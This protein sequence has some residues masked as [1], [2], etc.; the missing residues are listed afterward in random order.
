MRSEVERGDERD[1]RMKDAED[2]SRGVV[3]R[4]DPALVDLGK[5]ISDCRQCVLQPERQPLPHEPRPVCV[6]SSHARIA[7]CGQAPGTRV[8][9][10]G[11]P[12][13]DP[14]G[15]RLRDWLGIGPEVF[16]D[17][18]RVAIVPMGFCFPGL[19]A[20][21]GDRPPR[22]EC[23]KLWHDRVFEAMPNVGLRIVIGSYAQAY[24][25]GEHRR[26]TLSA[27]VADWR[28]VLAATR[29]EGRPAIALPHPSW[30]NNAWLRRNPWF[31]QECLP[32][33][34]EEV[35]ALLGEA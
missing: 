23:R 33:L 13:T 16:Y 26:S 5:R 14:S 4:G 20:K 18:C 31:E 24:H 8:H 6:L 27:T 17:P 28:E 1:G 7:I 34:R 30:R 2:E 25:L 19:D 32:V 35:A 22:S 10:S 29:K 3:V 11:R 15:D 21:G 12:F 9:A